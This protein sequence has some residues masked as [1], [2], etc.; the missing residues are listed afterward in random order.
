M[1]MDKPEELENPSNI[2][3]TLNPE[4]SSNP[5]N[6]PNLINSPN[7]LY[8]IAQSLEEMAEQAPFRRAI[9]FPAGRDDQDRSGRSHQGLRHVC[10]GQLH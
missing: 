6:P 5:S 2:S 9:V 7:S 8:N 1:N 3:N 10:Q 4:N